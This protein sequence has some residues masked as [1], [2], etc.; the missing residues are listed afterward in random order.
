MPLYIPT[1][2]VLF[3]ECFEE[4]ALYFHPIKYFCRTQSEK[5]VGSIYSEML[6]FDESMKVN[7]GV[8]EAM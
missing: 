8:F 5:C 7:I 1:P 2:T 6:A 3:R 4:Y